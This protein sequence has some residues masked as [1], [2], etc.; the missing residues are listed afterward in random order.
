MSFAQVFL[1]LSVR[2]TN[3]LLTRRNK[4]LSVPSS[5]NLQEWNF[6]KHQVRPEGE[7]YLEA[8]VSKEAR[9]SWRHNRDFANKTDTIYLPRMYRKKCNWIYVNSTFILTQPLDPQS[10]SSKH[11]VGWENCCCTSVFVLRHKKHP[12]TFLSDWI[13]SGSFSSSS[14]T[15]WSPRAPISSFEWSLV[16]VLRCAP[17]CDLLEEE[18]STTQHLHPGHSQQRNHCSRTQIQR[19]WRNKLLW[20]AAANWTKNLCPPQSCHLFHVSQREQLQWDTPYL[21]SFRYQKFTALTPQHAGS[22]IL[23]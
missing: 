18:S 19:N 20:A 4:G 15:F 11:V 1:T 16:P 7:N 14:V 2:Q 8:S 12:S 21:P 5:I 22:T 9:T 23:Y 6:Q 10:Q 3:W 13:W 17:A